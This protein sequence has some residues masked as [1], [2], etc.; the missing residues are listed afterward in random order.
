[1]RVVG[2]LAL[3]AIAASCPYLLGRR[4]ERRGT[5]AHLVAMALSSMLAMA[6]STVVV[7]GLA[8]GT[9]N[10]PAV[11]GATLIE[12]CMGSVGQAITHPERH[13][14]R[15][16]AALLLALVIG[17]LLWAI[18]ATRRAASR[19]RRSLLHLPSEPSPAGHVVV[20]TSAPL[21]FTYVSWGRHVVVIS[22]GLVERLSPRSLS[23]V[24][25]HERAHAR[26]RHGMLHLVGV[27]VT[28]A[29]SFAPPMIA[30]AD[31]LILGLELEA[32]RRALREIGD[33]A[34]LAVALVDVAECSRG[35]LGRA[36]AT[37]LA[38]G[39]SGVA[40]RVERLM[41]PPHPQQRALGRAAAVAAAATLVL[42]LV[43]LPKSVGALTG[44]TQV[45][46]AHAACHLSRQDR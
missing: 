12:R 10:R 14:S 15:I 5:G 38:A 16:V 25:A 18:V 11:W 40:R 26:G 36:P 29:F 6:I 41:Q 2:T 4:L 22:R 42:L 17:R 30:A 34:D 28:R 33:P 7:L 13:W 8:V 44:S 23:C 9:V 24:L 45:E 20:D 43:A 3:A 19:E 27:A 31:Q 46:V 37:A 35:R 32:D 21:A 39:S 1:M